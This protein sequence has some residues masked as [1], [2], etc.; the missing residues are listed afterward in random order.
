M[1]CSRQFT[2]NEAARWLTRVVLIIVRAFYRVIHS[3]HRVRVR[4]F[5]GF[6]AKGQGPPAPP[7]TVDSL[8]QSNS[9]LVYNKVIK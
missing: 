3:R 5:N 2:Q 4:R 1:L 8:T 7:A 6:L 9:S